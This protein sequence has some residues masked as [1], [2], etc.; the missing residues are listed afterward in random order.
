MTGQRV[1]VTQRSSVSGNVMTEYDGVVVDF[2]V[3]VA[4]YEGFIEERHRII[5][6]SDD[7]RFFF[8]HPGDVRVLSAVP[9]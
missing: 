8:C 7:G 5:V 1:H 6:Q 9:A 4:G 2:V 3:G